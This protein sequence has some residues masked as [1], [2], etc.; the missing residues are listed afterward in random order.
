MHEN[1]IKQSFDLAKQAVRN[2]DHP[3]GAL[4]VHDNEVILT[5]QNTVNSDS[6]F[7]KHAEMNL[8]HEAAKKY[9]SS[10]M[11]NFT[12]YTSTEPCMMCSGA[13]YWSGIHKIVY[14]CSALALQEITE[15]A[16]LVS[17]R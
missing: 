12:L 8:L 2:G 9:S 13:I 15:D 4:L 6:D 16:F 10:Q 5:A 14:G 11:S 1:L 17:C 3:F 7:T